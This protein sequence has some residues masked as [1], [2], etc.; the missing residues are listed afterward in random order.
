ME[1]FTNTVAQKDKEIKRLE[2]RSAQF[3]RELDV[4]EEE[5]KKLWKKLMDQSDVVAHQEDIIKEQ[6]KKIASLSK[7]QVKHARVG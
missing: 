5:S 6:T 3:E 4:S 2:S 7:K 1:H